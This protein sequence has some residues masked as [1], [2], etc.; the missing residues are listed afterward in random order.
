MCD[1]LWTM[2][3]VL[4]NQEYRKSPKTVTCLQE[5]NSPFLLANLESINYTVFLRVFY[6]LL[7]NYFQ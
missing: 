5:E 7:S 3:D 2:Y 4:K 1:L 6:R